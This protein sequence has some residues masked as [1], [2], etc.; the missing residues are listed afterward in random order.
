MLF[1]KQEVNTKKLHFAR[2]GGVEVSFLSFN[3]NNTSSNPF[4]CLN[5]FEKNENKPK[6]VKPGVNNIEKRFCNLILYLGTFGKRR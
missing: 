3:S 5:L 6:I 4:L 1:T 2:G